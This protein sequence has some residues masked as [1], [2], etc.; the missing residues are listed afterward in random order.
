MGFFFF[1][2]GIS[3]GG[4]LF[5]GLSNDGFG[6]EKRWVSLNFLMFLGG[7]CDP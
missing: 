1:F 7:V 4:F 3:G 2:F 5:V 6:F